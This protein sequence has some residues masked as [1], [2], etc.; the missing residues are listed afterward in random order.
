MGVALILEFVKVMS[1]SLQ[2]P[3]TV[4]LFIFDEGS[5][6]DSTNKPLYSLTFLLPFIMIY[7]IGTYFI[8]TDHLGLTQMRVVTF[9][10]L[11]QFAQYFG[12]DPR[13]TLAFP[14]LVVV[15]ILFC[16]HM[17]SHFPW[18]I[19]IKWLGGM[20]IESLIYTLPLFFIGFA[21]NN[22]APPVAAAITGQEGSPS[23]LANITTSIGAG[24]Y[25]ELVFRLILIGLIIMLLEDVLKVKALRATIIAVVFS[26][27]VF[28]LHH[29]FGFTSQG[30]LTMLAPFTFTSFTFRTIAGGYFALLFKYRGFGIIVGTHMAYDILTFT[31][32]G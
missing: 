14:G 8:N 10:W 30:Q 17:A 20:A 19:N 4:G 22:A 16:W 9:T 1:L 21:M 25:E 3:G 12:M 31:L 24:L 28:S 23:Y 32:N 13:L 5:Y 11:Q 27:V 26:A 29:N 6:L 7:E 15:V 18:Q 2:K